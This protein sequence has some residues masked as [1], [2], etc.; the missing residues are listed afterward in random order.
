[1]ANVLEQIA[2]VVRLFVS[3]GPSQTQPLKPGMCRMRIIELVQGAA[4][5]AKHHIARVSITP[6]AITQTVLDPV[7]EC[8]HSC[9]LGQ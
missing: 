8:G 7:Q 5:D 3:I 1:M 6:H 4:H 9:P 2:Q